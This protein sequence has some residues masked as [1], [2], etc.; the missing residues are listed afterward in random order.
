LTAEPPPAAASPSPAAAPSPA[1]PFAAGLALGALAAGL[2]GLAAFRVAGSA[3]AGKAPE[4]PYSVGADEVRVHA[5]RPAMSFETLA[6][7]LG[8]PLSRPPV[9]ARVATLEDRTAPSFA[10]L[11]GRVERVAVHIGDRVREGDKLVLVRSGDLAGLQRDLEAAK[12]SIETKRALLERLDLLVESR[13]VSKNDLLVAR[14]ELNEARLTATAAEARLRSL[15]VRREGETGYWV[16]ATRSGTVVQI[17]ATP[18]K[19]VGPDKDRP[20]ATVADLDEVLVLADVPPKDANTL[21]PGLP[22]AIEVPGAGPPVP[23]TVEIIADVMDA[24]RQTVPV[25]VRAPNREMKLRPHAF[26]NAVFGPAAEGAVMQLP[27]EAVV[28][29][30]STSVVFVEVAPGSFRRRAVTL[31]RQTKEKVEITGGLQP[32][33]R[34]VVRGALL[35][36]NALDAHG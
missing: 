35:L 20:V 29:D 31:G 11:D 27:A 18:G 3:G 13:A 14:S 17:D 1:R 32:G 34:A 9:T 16:L 30:G 36:L 8:P 28:S 5:S 23:G 19:Q 10:P 22:V 26:V 24:D 25:R 15:T 6:V 2:V 7:E 33:E 4:P 12:L 21:R